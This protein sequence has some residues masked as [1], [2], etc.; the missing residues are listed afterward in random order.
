LH[1]P[2]PLHRVD[3]I[4]PALFATMLSLAH[5]W[6][7]H[8][9]QPDTVIGH[10]QGEITAAC[11]AGALT[12][13]DAARL[14]TLR[15]KALHKITGRGGM[16]S[17]SLP[18]SETR[19]LIERWG[20]KLSV[21]AI[22][23][24]ETTV[25]SGDADALDELRAEAGERVRRISVDYASHSPHVESLRE[26]LLDLFADIQPQKTDITFYST[27]TGQAIDPTTLDTHY[28]YDN[29]RQPVRFEQT[30]RALLDTGHHT[31]IE[32]S[33]HPVL[34]GPMS[35]IPG[36]NAVGT[37]RRGDGG[38]DRFLS[39]LAR[40]HVLGANVDWSTVVP[41]API[42]SLPTYP[43]QR[44][45]YWLNPV[46]RSADAESAGLRADDHALLGASAELAVS[47]QRL[48]TGRWSVADHPWLAEHVV[49]GVNLL[50]ATAFVDLALYAG[51]QT[52]CPRLAEL[53][54]LGP[55]A[56]GPDEVFQTQ[57]TVEPPDEH[58]ARGL[59]VHA[60]PAGAEQWTQY[61]TGVLT[62]AE[63]EQGAPAA[64][65]HGTPAEVSYKRLAERGYAYGPEF[66]GLR[67]FRRSGDELAA[68]IEIELDAD[69][70]AVH[71]A[72]L[73]ACLHPLLMTGGEHEPVRM[74][75]NWS[76]VQVRTRGA[77][78]VR[79]RL[80]PLD[81]DGVRVRATDEAGRTV[82]T[83]DR[84]ALRPVDLKSLPAA[85][86]DLLFR[87]EWTSLPPQSAPPVPGK[88]WALVGT[89]LPGL[90]SLPAHPGLTELV[91]GGDL[92]DTV[93]LTCPPTGAADPVA[94]THEAV[95]GF[96]GLLQEWLA[97]ARVEG[98]RLVVATVNAQNSGERDLAAAAVWGL[99][100]TAQAEHPGR[101]TLLDLD[102]AQ[103]SRQAL[104][105]ALATEEP[106]LAIRGGL[107]QAHRLARLSAA[108]ADAP[109]MFPADGTV[110]ITGG[111]GALAEVTARHLVEAHGVRHLLLASRR[112]T[113]AP[114]TAALADELAG[115][116]ARVTVAVCDAADRDELAG[117]LATI[118]AEHP[119]SAVIHTA[120]VVD[121]GVV[122]ALTRK[123]VHAVLRPKVDAAWNLHELTKDLGLCAFVLYSSASAVLGNPGQANYGAANSF[124]DALADIRR[125]EGLPVTSMAW[126]LWELRAGMAGAL[127]EK[128]KD[129]FAA[130]GIAPFSAAQGLAAFDGA[131]AVDNAVVLPVRLDL[132]AL[133][134]R[135]RSGELD[136]MF[137]KV[138]AVAP[139]ANAGGAR[140]ADE[141][142]LVHRLAPLSEAARQELVRELVMDCIGTVLGHASLERVHAERSFK[143]LGFDS[144]MAVEL[145]NGLGAATGLRLP[146]TLVFDHPNPAALIDYLAGLA[147]PGEDDLFAP[148][149]VEL[150]RLRSRFD[151]INAT[152]AVKDEIAERL[153][154]LLKR[155]DGEEAPLTHATDDEIFDFI[156]NELGVS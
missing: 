38:M 21:A 69:A 61:A 67:G 147:A 20:D 104:A 11:H 23:G 18:E 145:R 135:A 71:P 127:S 60:R 54:L 116:G 35:E 84:I 137:R 29:L 130:S 91:A 150:D 113:Q 112:G 15:S 138:V 41:A 97:D 62:P 122:G 148:L 98:C 140:T 32:A 96:L 102:G 47:G 131:L 151:E 26:E 80:T 90:E 70:H 129:R 36:V 34:T 30:T 134:T 125:A 132:G 85:E 6:H 94:A 119:L 103:V 58:G 48:F 82:L 120:G 33:P 124:L 31:F 4:Q 45:H 121:G 51:E 109:P 114:G 153:R 105:G 143:E 10:S 144:L 115:Q 1:D 24:P 152:G 57:V 17:V 101:I 56:M 87:L 64:L 59:A 77:K 16:A 155:V 27:V 55:L 141:V 3:V 72:L 39:S 106:Q 156:D 83:I 19:E 7:T 65:P 133:R 139:A 76:G 50:P 22:N 75:F 79:V 9:L 14:I 118:P 68:E 43:F 46:R 100:R 44:S 154:G 92:P 111:S 25:V 53:T 86:Q 13:H 8:G 136:S 123:S 95:T 89:P 81:Q 126:G 66:Q 149:I 108:P 107:A 52:G 117:L 99:V 74:P 88:A 49:A 40:A 78:A 42:V 73:D 12:L 128:D 5:L 146:A 2:T 110:L 63:P 142:P 37:L 93:F 28:W